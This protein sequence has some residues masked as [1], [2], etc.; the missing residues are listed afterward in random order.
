M[1]DLTTYFKNIQTYDEQGYIVFSALDIYKIFKSQMDLPT[2]LEFIE[3]DLDSNS[4]YDV[5]NIKF[6][7]F[8]T[9]IILKDLKLAD[10]DVYAYLEIL[11]KKEALTSQI[12]A[13]EKER[14]DLIKKRLQIKRAGFKQYRHVKKYELKWIENRGK[15]IKELKRKKINAYL[16]LS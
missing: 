4:I 10:E 3:V 6:S 14:K 5:K 2:F 1:K 15:Q 16:A 9:A 8:T 7:I 12:L 13:L 11:S